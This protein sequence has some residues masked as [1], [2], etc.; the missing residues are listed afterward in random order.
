MNMAKLRQILESRRATKMPPLLPP[1]RSKKDF[2]GNKKNNNE[3]SISTAIELYL[4]E[5][6]KSIELSNVLSI[7]FQLER[8]QYL[9]LDICN[10]FENQNETKSFGYCIFSV[11]ELICVRGGKIKRKLIN[12]ENGKEIAEALLSCTLR[13]KTHSIILQFAASN[14]YKKG[15]NTTTQIY[16]E[17]YQINCFKEEINEEQKISNGE[18]NFLENNESS[19]TINKNLLIYKSES[20][21]W[22]SGRIIWKTF[23]VQ[24]NEI[25]LGKL[26]FICIQ[27]SDFLKLNEPQILGE[28]TTNFNNLRKGQGYENIYFLSYVGNRNRKKSAGNFELCRFNE[29]YSPSFLEYIFGGCS[30]NLSFAVDFSRSENNVDEGNIRRYINDVELAIEAFGEPLNEFQNANSYPAFGFGAKIPPQFRESQEFCLNLETDPYCRGISS[31]ISAFKTSFVNVQPLNIA[32]LSHVIYYVAKL[33]QNSLCR[34]SP[35][36]S[37][38]I[39][40][41]TD[42][43]LPN[44]F[45]LVIITRGVFDDLKETVQAIIF[46]SRSP[47]SIIFVEISNDQKNEEISELERLATAGT[48][49]NFHGRKPERDCTQYVSIP[50]YCLEENKQNDLKTLIAEKGLATIGQQMCTWMIKNG[51]QKLPPNNVDIQMRK[52]SLS[53]SNLLCPQLQTVQEGISGNAHYSNNLTCNDLENLQNNKGKIIKNSFITTTNPFLNRKITSNSVPVKNSTINAVKQQFRNMELNNFAFSLPSSPH[54]Q[55]ILNNNKSLSKNISTESQNY[56]SFRSPSR[57]ITK[58]KTLIQFE[59]KNNI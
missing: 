12:D 13:P 43:N 53:T 20:I 4:N 52:T 6:N 25:C 37:T 11:S 16:F 56:L 2:I 45:I 40:V 30:I 23:T 57:R 28:F 7:E 44:Y 59:K 10:L 29:V 18:G 26:K 42:Y 39:E 19:S 32:H 55:N 41:I 38:S 1:K 9:R 34:I 47:V 8:Q 49:L 22:N 51:Y 48:R 21:K 46:A 58:A 50:N 54:H 31:V 5:I 15:I 36:L 24:S 3:S 27:E 33:A 17:I 14:L 35:A